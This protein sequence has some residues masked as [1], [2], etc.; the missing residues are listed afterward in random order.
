MPQG[1]PTKRQTVGHRKL[2]AVL[3]P[4]PVWTKT[5]IGKTVGASPQAVGLWLSEG[6]IPRAKFREILEAELGIPQSDWEIDDVEAG[7]GSEAA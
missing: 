4:P 1:Q 7:S 3:D 6:F 2:R 5:R